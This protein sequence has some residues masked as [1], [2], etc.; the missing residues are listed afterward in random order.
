MIIDKESQVEGTN[1]SD[2]KYD[3]DVRQYTIN[4]NKIQDDKKFP[5]LIIGCLHHSL[6]FFEF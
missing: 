6:R 2:E 4:K 1:D 5:H 3:I